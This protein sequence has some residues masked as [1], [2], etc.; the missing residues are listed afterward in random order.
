MNPEY[1][2]GIVLITIERLNNKNEGCSIKNLVEHTHLGNKTVLKAIGRLADKKRISIT[3]GKPTKPTSYKILTPPN[4]YDYMA[5][6]LHLESK[7][8]GN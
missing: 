3:P 7:R 5:I 8:N 4:D 1:Y 2:E 6:S